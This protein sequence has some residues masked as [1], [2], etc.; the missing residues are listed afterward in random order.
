MATEAT[1]SLLQAARLFG[2]EPYPR[3]AEILEQ[4]DSGQFREVVLACGRRSGKNLMGAIVAL[5]DA[6]FRD[7]R[8]YLRRNEKRYIVCVAASREQAG[9]TLDYCRQ[10]LEETR[11]QEALLEETADELVIRQPGTGAPVA[12]KTMPCSAR[13]G[14]GLAISTLVLDELAHW[15]SESEGYQVA[16]RVHAALSPSVAQF[17]ED[18]RLLYLSTPWGQSGLFATLF[19]RASSGAH[20]DMLAITAPTWEMNPTL[21][22]DFFER[23]RAKDPELF[24]GEYG[25]EFLASGA[26]FLDHE[27]I[28]AAVDE[29]R[30]ELPVVDT[31][32]PVAALD[33]SFSTDPFGFAIVGRHHE[34]TRKLRLA[35]VRSWRPPRGDELGFEPVL[36]E[37]AELCHSYK[38]SSV[39]TDQYT[40][41]PVRQHLA[42][43]GVACREL[44]MT[45]SS[46][47]AVYSS[48]KSKMLAGELELY[49][50]KPLLAELGRIEA[51]YSAGS[52]SIR[53]PRVGGSHG[54]MA[55]A[56]ALAVHE[57]A[58][59]GYGGGRV[60]PRSPGGRRDPG[61]LTA[62]VLDMDF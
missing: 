23:E 21:G 53:I 17:K 31:K 46:K 8:P 57:Q 52:A 28:E 45:A 26:Q 1:P 6:L 41:V 47:T 59:R 42:K 43:R 62:G 13:T 30:F 44:T 48:L 60:R 7:L 5:H 24:R 38:V 15:V 33:P 2:V 25:A 12:I 29:D 54:D 18:G 40:S 10:L 55:Q 20:A 35:V 32:Q 4:I 39:L 22:E 14:R 51:V 50:H 49:R 56:V 36:D 16:D 9:L 58:K 27:R 11:L 37:I 3:Q 61:A 34:D 19:E